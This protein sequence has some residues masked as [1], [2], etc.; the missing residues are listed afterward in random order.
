MF[1]RE[2]CPELSAELEQT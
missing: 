2:L 1:L